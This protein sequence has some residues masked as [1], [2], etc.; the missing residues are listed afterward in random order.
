LIEDENRL[1]M[2]PVFLCI[3]PFTPRSQNKS[4]GTRNFL[5]HRIALFV[6]GAGN[7]NTPGDNP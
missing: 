7:A 3:E 6:V 1:Q 2:Q 5:E 4:D